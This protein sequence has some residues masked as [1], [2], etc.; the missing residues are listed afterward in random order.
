MNSSGLSKLSHSPKITMCF[1]KLLTMI[2][3]SSNMLQIFIPLLKIPLYHQNYCAQFFNSLSFK[4]NLG[5]NKRN[6][7][8]PGGIRTHNLWMMSCV[9]I[10]N[11]EGKH[12]TV[13]AFE[14]PTQPSRVR[15][16]LPG[17]LFVVVLL[18]Y[19]KPCASS[20]STSCG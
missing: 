16:R 14:F 12:S 17:K 3:L 13:E 5:N 19:L 7:P 10:L 2:L 6:S 18:N 4:Q 15:F 11:C 20:L 1:I 9:T 8:A